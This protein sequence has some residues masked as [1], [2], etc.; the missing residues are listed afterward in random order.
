MVDL[1]DA[2]VQ[3]CNVYFFNLAEKTGM[4]R[5]ARYAHEFGFGEPTNIGYN[6]EVAGFIPTKAWYE[7]KF[8]GQ[9]RIGF[10]LNAAIGQGNTK[11]TL[12][13]LSSAYAVIANHGTLYQP[14]VVQRVEDNDGDIVQE[15]GTRVVRHVSVKSENLDYLSS[16]LIGVVHDPGGTAYEARDSS[17]TVAGKTGTAQVARTKRRKGESLEK[18]WYYNRDHAWFAAFAPA[19]NPEISI[20]VLVDH[21]GYGGRFAAPIGMQ[22][23]KGYF[24]DISPTHENQQIADKRKPSKPSLHETSSRVATSI[25][26]H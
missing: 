25:H 26:P 5:I 7:Q 4:N 17:I 10:T 3:S 24:Q 14:Y 19:E 18:Y 6:S 2:I 20:I 11:V 8:P 22:I 1:H 12:M 9:F 21:G 23:I 16:S 13:Q 15:I